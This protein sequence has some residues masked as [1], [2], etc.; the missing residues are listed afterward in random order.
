MRFL[1]LFF[2]LFFVEYLDFTSDVNQEQ[3]NLVKNK[4]NITVYSRFSENSD[5]KEIKVVTEVDASLSSVV[6]LLKDVHNYPNWIYACVKS[7][8]IDQTNNY[9]EYYYTETD[10]PWPF[11]NRD[12]VMYSK[13]HQDKNT[14]ILRFNSVGVPDKYPLVKNIVRIN[15]IRVSWE[16][17]PQKN[18]TIK[19]HYQLKADPAGII[20]AWLANLTVDIGPYN[21][22]MNM[23]TELEKDQYKNA[24]L[25]YIIE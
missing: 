20:P 16:L 7:E 14:K 15:Q 3:W 8:L 24:K 13:M 10:T 21:T 12:I 6:A 4:N 2:T 1:F 18:N 5:F 11:Y 19:I 25:D 17:I 22:M 23:R 9:V